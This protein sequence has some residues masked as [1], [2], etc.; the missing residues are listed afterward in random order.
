MSRVLSLGRGL[1]ALLLMV[2]SGGGCVGA[3]QAVRTTS[4]DPAL[5]VVAPAWPGQYAAVAGGSRS[6]WPVA[7]RTMLQPT[8]IEVVARSGVDGVVVDSSAAV[9]I[10]G[11]AYLARVDPHTGAAKVWDVSDDAAFGT[12]DAVRPSTSG[13][14][15]L[16][17]GDRLRLFDGG[18]FVRDIRVP[19]LYRG[20][21]QADIADLV[22][23]GPEVWVASPGG[24]ARC[25]G[26]SW[27]MVGPGELT[28]VAQLEIDS[29]GSVWARGQM[30]P[31]QLAHAPTVVRFS[32][33]RWVRPGG[34]DSPTVAE[35]LVLD[36]SGGALVRAGV[37]V[38]RME[39]RSW[40]G[41]AMGR[42]GRVGPPLGLAAGPD[43]AP[44][45]WGEHYVDRYEAVGGW[46]PV[47]E[48]DEPALVDLA[49]VG[50][51]V[52]VA[53][54]AGLLRWEHDRWIRVWRVDS[55]QDGSAAGLVAAL[56]SAAEGVLDSPGESSVGL[57]ALSATQVWV[58]VTGHE[59]PFRFQ[60]G[61]WQEVPLPSPLD[62]GASPT[63][64]ADGAVWLSVRAGLVRIIGDDSELLRRIPLVGALVAADG[65]SVWVSPARWSGLW[66]PPQYRE[67]YARC[68]EMG[69]GSVL[70]VRA[71]GSLDPVSLPHDVWA[72]LA[73]YAG[74]ADTLWGTIC[75]AGAV[76]L[77]TSAPELLHWDGQWG[78]VPYPGSGISGVGPSPDGG[79]WATIT[80]DVTT[81]GPPD[82]AFYSGGTWATMPGTGGIR[83]A[84]VAPDGS[85]CGIDPEE[86]VFVCV[87]SSGRMQRSPVGLAEPIRIAPDGSV[88]TAI[89]GLVA[90]LPVTAG[91]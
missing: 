23:V 82:L 77:C 39:G 43:G 37:Q 91:P 68:R 17:S 81:G 6:W 71:D 1:V 65:G 49:L 67:D 13:G 47:L 56:S 22:E 62:W 32:G 87:D 11:P 36:S 86:S 29:A 83:W 38:T 42:S 72:P 20:G 33:T 63:A 70:H 26:Q 89:P 40:Q 21:A 57:L 78:V 44:W 61:R 31:G 28:W 52:L 54:D 80:A 3:G 34:P 55:D 9:W 51:L 76:P 84:E 58:T 27:S 30:R 24:V 16:V 41:L 75:T 2:G 15:W 8:G 90:R 64:S 74:D 48:V 18:R 66:P 19:A 73:L 46:R 25:D 60:D 14:V 69:G 4:E 45:L 50:D 5:E 85:V 59:A 53:D 88:W 7:T 79:F 35:D 12:V 10:D